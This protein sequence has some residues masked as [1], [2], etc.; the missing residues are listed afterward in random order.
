MD[1]RGCRGSHEADEPRRTRAGVSW[2]GVSGLSQGRRR[3]STRRR[4]RRSSVYAATTSQVQRSACSGV[5]SA[6]VVQPRVCLT[7]RNVCSRSKRRTYAR[8]QTSRSGSP[9]PDHHSQS[10]FF[11][12]GGGSGQVLDVHP[13]H[14]PANDR[15]VGTDPAP[16]VLELR[17]QAR[18]GRHLDPAV[19]RIVA[20][21]GG[22]RSRPG[23]LLGAG[24]PG[25]VAPR[26]AHRPRPGRDRI[27]VEE[28]VAAD[29]DADGRPD[30]G[31]AR[32]ERDRVVA[33]VEHEERG[34]GP[35]GPSRSTRERTWA[36]VAPTR[37]LAERAGRRRGVPSR[38]RAR[39]KGPRSTGRTSRPRSA[40]RPSGGTG[41][42][43]FH[44]FWPPCFARNGHPV[45][46]ETDTLF[47]G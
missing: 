22:A 41:G 32:G 17:M 25:P 46:P 12:L 36:S 13:D 11:A 21:E 4:A 43:G 3:P 15:R 18:P 5:R 27:G 38:S 34:T 10:V 47:H 28:P 39:R 20:G 19:A 30:V 33:G 7:K 42:C 23:G 16:A 8:Q 35:S 44:G 9:G 45:S 29:A 31:E 2:A 24:E 14:R 40:G 37:S 6:G 26:P 1:W